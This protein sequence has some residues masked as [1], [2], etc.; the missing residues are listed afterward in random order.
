MATVIVSKKA[1][2][3]TE[4]E[5]IIEITSFISAKINFLSR[6]FNKILDRMVK[7]AV[8]CLSNKLRYDC[9]C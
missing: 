5:N 8:F 4:F 2:Y 9:N 6:L 1:I 7:N 3:L